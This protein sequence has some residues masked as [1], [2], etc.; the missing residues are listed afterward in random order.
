MKNSC[1]LVLLPLLTLL[2]G[3]RPEGVIPSGD[4]VAILSDFYLADAYIESN[5][6]IEGVWQNYRI[7]EPIVEKHGYDKAAFNESLS[8][9]LHH[10]DKLQ[11]IFKRTEAAL[12]ALDV[13]EI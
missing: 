2:V 6:D 12:K 11:K 3:C 10:P 4:M 13:H 8:W 5:P 7:Y 1:L 9:Y